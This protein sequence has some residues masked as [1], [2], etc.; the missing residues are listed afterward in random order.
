MY[1]W[2]CCSGIALILS[3]LSFAVPAAFG[4]QD[5][6]V[7]R[8][9]QPPKLDGSAGDAVWGEAKEIQVKDSRRGDMVT[10]KAV[11]SGEMVY[12]LVTFPDAE[13]NR[14]HKP[15]VWDKD[16]SVYTL[17]PQRE[18]GFTF[19]WNMEKRKVNLSN[20]SD[21]NYRADVWYWKAHRTDPA[22]YADDKHHLLSAEPGKKAKEVSSSTG[23]KRYLT[24][25]GDEGEGAQ[26][27]RILTDY[28]GDVQ[29][30][31]VSQKPTGSR[32][33]VLAKGVWREGAWT[34]EFGRKLKTGNDDDVQFD[35]PSGSG[36]LFGISIFGLYGEGLDE[37]KDHL[38][39]QGRISEA[40]NL[41][42]P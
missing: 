9:G 31:Y 32:A 25:S 3:V 4:A 30:Q 6:T 14:L 28:Q 35:A 8:V 20:F 10:L 27:K 22:G 2:I 29:E 5:L 26:K 39:G 1:G 41:L 24:R 42:L 7:V 23:K 17:G 13:E 18:D 16:M 11:V 38:Y 34:V 33:D 36:Y 15:W 21:D 37:S 19:K 40:L 12:F